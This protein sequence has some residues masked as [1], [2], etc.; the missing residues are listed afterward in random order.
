MHRP[1]MDV[2]RRLRDGPRLAH[3]DASGYA[4]GMRAHD[5]L[6]KQALTQHADDRGT[7]N[8]RLGEI[9]EW[10]GPD[11]KHIDVQLALANL[12]DAGFFRGSPYWEGD[13]VDGRFSVE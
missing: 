8:G 12:R 13:P 10:L 2:K 11:G 7:V 1:W 3:V 6:V 5:R 4:C 9:R